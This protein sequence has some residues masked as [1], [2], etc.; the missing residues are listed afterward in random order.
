MRRL[1]ALEDKCSIMDFSCTPRTWSWSAPAFPSRTRQS[2]RLPTEIQDSG[3]YFSFDICWKSRKAVLIAAYLDKRLGSVFFHDSYLTLFFFWYI[4]NGY[5]EPFDRPSFCPL[6]LIDLCAFF[7]RWFP[8]TSDNYWNE[9]KSVGIMQVRLLNRCEQK[10]EKGSH[11]RRNPVCDDCLLKCWKRR[12][13]LISSR[14]E[15]K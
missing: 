7:I 12:N 4:L 2:I 13:A 8:F 3:A 6:I 11:Y 9:G 1:S 10:N 5:R 14:F 15:I